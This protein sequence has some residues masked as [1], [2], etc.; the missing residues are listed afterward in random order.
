M[1]LS[2]CALCGREVLELDG[3]FQRN[4]SYLLE[5]D[6]PDRVPIGEVHVPCLVTSPWGAWWAARK[7]A[8]RATRALPVLG[9][10]PGVIA[11]RTVDGREILILRDDG[12][13]LHLRSRDLARAQRIDDGAL[14][15]VRGEYH[16]HLDGH[17]ELAAAIAARVAAGGCPLPW[18]VDQLG[19]R[20]TLFEPRAIEG[21]AYVELP[22]L[23]VHVG[24]A[25]SGTLGYAVFVP[26]AMWTVVADQ[27]PE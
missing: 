24:N 16:L 18:I 11:H 17:A 2:T 6:D 26:F 12:V 14:V 27:R 5:R 8:N 22:G 13:D 4:D 7:R 9:A 25:V 3:Q 15:P 20:D 19:L 10:A 21:G 1:R 23:P